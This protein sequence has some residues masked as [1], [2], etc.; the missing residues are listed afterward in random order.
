M[1]DYKVDH[2]GEKKCNAHI[3]IYV[4]IM[5]NRSKRI[6]DYKIDF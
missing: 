6:S 2:W 1:R 4:N 3:I 5:N